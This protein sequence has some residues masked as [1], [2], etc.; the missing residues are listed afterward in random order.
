MKGF[1]TSFLLLLLVGKAPAQM[2]SPGQAGLN[3]A[4]LKLFGNAK[5][6]SSQSEA[7]T[8][9]KAGKEM[10]SLKMKFALLDNKIRL[11]VDLAQLKSAEINPQMVASFKQVGMDK[12]VSIVRLD[13]KSTL[14][15]YPA[16]QAYTEVP[17]STEDAADLTKEFTVQKTALGAET[18]DGHPCQKNKVIVTDPK[19]ARQEALVWNARD[20]QD[21]PIQM[22][23]M[24]S[25]GT[26]LL[27]YS[28][29]R[30][31][32]PEA[33]QFE[34][35]PGFAKHEGMEKLMQAAMTKSLGGK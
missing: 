3:A 18:L 32:R 17:M 15:V 20:L 31:T 16:L 10:M 22:Q 2:V 26:I 30:L 14:V 33:A 29:V 6:F 7:R 8:L 34:A 4:M 28:E 25:D 21:F 24:Q 35:P 12:L 1:F 13:R 5:A 11:D 19:G 23:I 9:D 27:R